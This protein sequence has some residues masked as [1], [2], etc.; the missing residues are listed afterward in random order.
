MKLSLS[1]DSMKLNKAVMEIRYDNAYLLWDRSGSIWSEMNSIWPGLIMKIAEPNTTTFVVDDRYELSVQIGKALFIDRKA[2]RS[3]KEF[4]ENAEIFVNQ[5]AES[6]NLK[7]FTRLGFRLIFSKKYDDKILAAKDLLST[8]LLK[9]PSG[10]HFNIDGKVIMPQYSMRWEGDSAGLRVLLVAQDKKVELEIN[11]DIYELESVNF[12][13][14]EIVYDIDY[15]TLKNTKKGQLNVSEW[16]SQAYHAV[17]RDSKFFF[18][19]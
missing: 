1:L 10:K 18:G 13:R 3:L 11:P 6:L 8:N 2:S 12:T 16:I 17:K 14:S 4:K 15:Y 7:E 19:E 9:V 5:V